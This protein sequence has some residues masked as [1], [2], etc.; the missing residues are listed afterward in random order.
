M[1]YKIKYYKQ[2][3]NGVWLSL[4]LCQHLRLIPNQVA[5][6]HSVSSRVCP[7]DQSFVPR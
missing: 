3:N 6:K 5:T 2:S 7:V 4:C 1:K